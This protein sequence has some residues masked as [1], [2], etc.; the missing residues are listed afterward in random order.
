MRLRR[1]NPVRQEVV[2]WQLLVGRPGVGAGLRPRADESSLGEDH[3]GVEPDRS[4]R[5]AGRQLVV[6]VAAG[7]RR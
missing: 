5:R 6:P 2:A 3:R 7:A 4:T 1:N